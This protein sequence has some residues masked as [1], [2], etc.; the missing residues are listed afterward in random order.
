[1]AAAVAVAGIL[2]L[3]VAAGPAAA[4]PHHGKNGCISWWY[5]RG[6][7]SLSL[8]TSVTNPGSTLTVYGTGF[9]SDSTVYLS[10]DP[11]WQNNQS[12][13]AHFH[14]NF[15]LTSATTDGHGD[16]SQLVTI[17][18]G[19]PLG[20]AVIVANG[21]NPANGNL[22][23]SA[24]L[25]IVHAPSGPVATTTTVSESRTSA[26]YGREDKVSFGVT[27][28]PAYGPAP[29]GQAVTIDVG[30]ASCVVTLSHGQGWCS[31]GS[32]ALPVSTGNA[33]TAAFLG[34][35]GY[36]AS[37]ST[38]TVDFTVTKEPQYINFGWLYGKTL[39]ESPIM[40]SA[41]ASSGLPVSFTTST[42]LVCSAGGTNGATI[43]L[44]TPGRCTVVASQAGSSTY[45]AAAPVAQYFQIPSSY[46]YHRH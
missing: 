43:T 6:K 14:H 2:P 23:L 30:S 41:T 10:L 5:V 15:G 12:H 38:N 46:H 19:A 21:L 7:C 29:S 25:L 27:V 32:T 11:D 17:P 18:S 4:A 13:V 35:S 9:K 42:P 39:S 45:A 1:V 36:V 8:S 34:S 24:N 16:F 22:D 26:P 37:A 28:S 20:G 31:I 40:V 33:V 3:A 44:L